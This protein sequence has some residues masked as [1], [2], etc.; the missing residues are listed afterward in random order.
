MNPPRGALV[1]VRIEEGFKWGLFVARYPDGELALFYGKKLNKVPAQLQKV[2]PVRVR[3]P[4]AMD[5]LSEADGAALQQ[6]FEAAIR[7][8][9]R[10][11]KEKRL[12]KRTRQAQEG[13]REFA[14]ELAAFKAAL[15][16]LHTTGVALGDLWLAYGPLE[17][18]TNA[19]FQAAMEQL[20]AEV[21]PYVPMACITALEPFLVEHG[22]AKLWLE[23]GR[24]RSDRKA[25]QP[26]LDEAYAEATNGE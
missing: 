15:Q 8:F 3:L 26:V 22:E 14:A 23:D 7:E 12:T 25:L 19:Q 16:E 18:M 20:S 6:R 4:E 24:P 21:D 1:R 5:E 9:E 2:A 17:A 13:I 10:Q 11:E